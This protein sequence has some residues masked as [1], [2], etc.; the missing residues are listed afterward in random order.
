MCN[1]KAKATRLRLKILVSKRTM[2][3]TV[4]RSFKNKP[5]ELLV[6]LEFHSI[7]VDTF[8]ISKVTIT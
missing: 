1:M 2:F 8:T 7:A 3:K 4:I 5:T 6:E